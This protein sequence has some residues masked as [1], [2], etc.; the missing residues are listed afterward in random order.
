MPVGREQIE[1]AARRIA[2][3]V[4]AT[5]VLEPGPG[6]F[7]VAS[8]LVLKLECLQHSGSFKARGAFNRLITVEHGAGV[9]A[10]SGGNFALAVAHAAAEL[11]VG[12]TIFVPE[13]TPAAKLARLRA[14]PCEV[15][16]AGAYYGEALAASREHAAESGAV[17]LHAFDDE[18]IVA[19]QGTCARE[20]DRQAAGLDTVLVAVGGAGLIG[21][22]AAWFAS[23]TRVVAVEPERCPA[24]HEALAAGAPMDVE[25]GGVAA[26]SLG[27]AR[28]GDIPFAIAT[29]HVQ[30]S[31]LVADEQIMEARRR[32]WDGARVVAEPG[33]AAALAALTAGVYEPQ[34]GERVGVLVCGA[35]TDPATVTV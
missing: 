18:V 7:G 29:E 24:L 3:H 9:V 2:G 20:F 8:P 1:E 28:V 14:H 33:G 35:N 6:A 27:A 11:N 5:P 13:S 30:R 23:G 34:P 16:V 25:V 4:R 15:V 26:D 31:L 22:V 32:L 12:A 19:G 10:A 17:E 21:G